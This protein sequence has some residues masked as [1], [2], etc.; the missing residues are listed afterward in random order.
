M[1]L[2]QGRTIGPQDHGEMGEPGRSHRGPGTEA[3][4]GPCWPGGLRPDDM[5]DF[6]SRIVDDHGKIIRSD[7][8]ERES[9]ISDLPA[10]KDMRPLTRSSNPRFGIHPERSE[11]G[12]P[13]SIRDC[14]SSGFR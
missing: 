1:T 4:A 5:G 13:D 3:A 11:A 10:V 6:H 2:A 12:R 9:Q 8:S 14:S 7:P